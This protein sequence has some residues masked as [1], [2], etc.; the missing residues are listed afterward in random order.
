MLQVT[1]PWMGGWR[2]MPW[3][4]IRPTTALQPA[5][6]ASQPAQAGAMAALQQAADAGK[7]LF[8]FVCDKDDASTR[9]A[10]KV[11]EAAVGKMDGKAQW[12]TVRR[13]APEEKAVVQKFGLKS[14][15]VPLVLAIAPNGAITG[16]I[17]AA[18]HRRAGDPG[19]RCQPLQPG[20][21]EGP[22]GPQG[23]PALRPEQDHQV[24]RGRDAGRQ[25]LQGRR[26]VRQLHGGRAGGP[27]RRGGRQVPDAVEGGP[28]GAGGRDGLPGP[29]DGHHRPVQGG[30]RQGDP[31]LDAAEG[32]QFGR[33]RPRRL[34]S[35]PELCS[36][37][38]CAP[39]TQSAAK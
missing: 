35:G 30:D 19:G 22:A 14:A 18:G 13:D 17:L 21:P 27:G 37:P 29:A 33:L 2:E 25:R 28:E 23:R 12:V 38:D 32:R 5:A 4:L 6:P 31:G 34:Q 15:P 7:Y 9:T 39:A 3:L 36:D 16:G 11:V 26:P 10:G 1:A 20:L 8:L 24:Q